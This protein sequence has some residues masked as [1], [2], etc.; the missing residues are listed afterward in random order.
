MAILN[1]LLLPSF[2][3]DTITRVLGPSRFLAN[4]F[5]FDID[6]AS[7]EQ[8]QG[9]VYTYDIYDNVR[10]VQ[11]ARASDA[12]A[13]TVAVNPVGNNTVTLGRFAEKIGLSYNQLLQIRRLGEN[14]GTR[15]VMGARYIE[16]QARTLKQRCMNSREFITGGMFQGGKYG[17][18]VSGDDWI[19]TY[20]VTNATFTVDMKIDTGNV[21][22]SPGAAFAAGLQMGTGANIITAAWSNAGT[23]IPLNLDKISSAFEDLVG[24]PLKRVYCGTDVWTNIIQNTAVKGVAGTANVSGSWDREEIKNDFGGVTTVIKS[25][26]KARPWIDFY[27]NDESLSLPATNATTFGNVKVLPRNAITFMIDPAVAPWM[28]MIEGSEVIKDND[29]SDP[30]ERYGFYAWAMEKADPARVWY[31]T[32]QI[33]GIELNLPKA[34]GFAIVQ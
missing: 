4:Q 5:G 1:D 25:T 23:D 19:P 9:K 22:G 30:V 15:D 29:W 3:R 6:G 7:T 24:A 12:P 20:D 18:F 27:V 34:M 31:L 16:R 2:V 13:G 10:T 8:V 32:N 14:A 11:N 33:L 21:L 28:K 26:I 17:Y